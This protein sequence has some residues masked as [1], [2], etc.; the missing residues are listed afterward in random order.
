MLLRRKLHEDD[1][2]KIKTCSSVSGLCVRVYINTSAIVGVTIK[3]LISNFCRV[4]YVV[5]FILG[6]PQLFSN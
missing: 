2:K 6:L 4:L 5:C 3:F 1:L